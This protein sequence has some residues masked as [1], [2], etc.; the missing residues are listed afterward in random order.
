VTS[1]AAIA[2]AEARPGLDRA[3]P[4]RW[5]VA[6]ACA[7]LFALVPLLRFGIGADG[8]VGVFFVAVLAVL[9]VKDVEERRIPNVVVLPATAIVLAAVAALHS[10]RA[11]EAILAG[12]AASAFLLL[13]SLFARGSVG[14]GDVKLALLLG[15]ALGKGVAAALLLGCL[16]ASIVGVVLIARH[17]AAARKTA[18]PFAPFLALGAVTAIA[19]GAPHAF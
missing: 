18:V 7:L 10:G 17:G 8:L 15:V 4:E 14:M 2:P 5:R 19:L 3:L 16:A 1:P 11:L 6:A 12:A 9:A 13:P